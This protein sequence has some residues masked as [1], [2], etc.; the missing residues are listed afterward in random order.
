M[1][2]LLSLL[3]AL[4]A[5]LFRCRRDLLLE[6]LALRQQLAVLKVRH[7]QPRFAASDKLFWVMLCRLWPGWKQ[8]LILVQPE[9]VVRWHRARFKLYWKWLSRHRTRAGR[10]CVSKELREL[11]FRMVAENPTWGAPRI[12]GELTM[13]GFD[14][15]SERCRVG[16]GRL[17]G[18]LSWRSVGRLS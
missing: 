10:R 15:R 5:R 6:N 1:Q 3:S 13:L 18:V 14:D 4:A 11:I 12:H 16:C 7:P 2:R 9:T 8:A 17:R